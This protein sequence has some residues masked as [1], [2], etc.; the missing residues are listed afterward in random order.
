MFA[1]STLLISPV[2]EFEFLSLIIPSFYSFSPSTVLYRCFVLW[3]FAASRKYTCISCRTRDP[4]EPLMN[5]ARLGS[6]SIARKKKWPARNKEPNRWLSLCQDIYICII[7]RRIKV[8]GML[9]DW[10]N[11]GCPWAIR[12]SWKFWK[13]CNFMVPCCTNKNL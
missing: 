6:R 12:N 7:N 9:L 1:Y 4:L 8:I 10:P 11:Q 5:I 3:P 2:W 13:E